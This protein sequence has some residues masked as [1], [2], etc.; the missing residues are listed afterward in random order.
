MENENRCAF[1]GIADG[2]F[3]ACRVWE[4]PEFLVFLDRNPIRPGHMQLITKAHYSYFDDLPTP[5][6]SG[7]IAAG[8]MLARRLKAIYEV[9]RVGFVCTGGDIAHCHAHIVPLHE[10]TDVT[11]L[12][13][14]EDGILLPT[15][16]PA[17][18]L[19]ELEQEAR[20][21]R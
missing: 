16:R 4:D 17:P 13:Y 15:A 9:T 7:F 3:S 6:A 8:Q 21:L 18:T 12:R 5:L 11:S 10:K 20:K 1:C 14:F 19:D 2:V